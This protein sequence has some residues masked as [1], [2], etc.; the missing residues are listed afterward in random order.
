MIQATPFR[1]CE[2]ER[3]WRLSVVVDLS[4]DRNGLWPFRFVV[5]LQ[6][7]DQTPTFMVWFSDERKVLLS[8]TVFWK[9]SHFKL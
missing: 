3:L 1:T 2:F 4:I 7:S 8:T 5:N 9:Y 6:R